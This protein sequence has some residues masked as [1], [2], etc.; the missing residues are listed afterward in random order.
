[1]NAPRDAVLAGESAAIYAY[2]VV[3]GQSRGVQRRRALTCL[4]AHEQWR[5]RWA[6]GAPFPAAVAYALPVEVT[7]ATTARALAQQVENGLVAL[8]A[9]LAA[10]SVDAKRVDAV[11]A[12]QQCAARAVRWGAA[13]Q[14]FPTAS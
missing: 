1:M 14:A 9:D 4:R 11:R 2:G 10:S 8:Y 5:D 13:T 7:D 3:A 12:A 6:E